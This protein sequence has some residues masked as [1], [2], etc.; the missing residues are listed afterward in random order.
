MSILVFS[1]VCGYVVQDTRTVDHIIY[2]VV[3]PKLL[4]PLGDVAVL[5]WVAIFYNVHTI[6]NSLIMMY[7]SNHSPVIK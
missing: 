2:T 3:D 6:T 1:I 5:V 4:L 7:F